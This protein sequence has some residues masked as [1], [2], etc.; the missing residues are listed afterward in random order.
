ML[1]ETEWVAPGDVTSIMPL[2]CD[3]YS[4]IDPSVTESRC[5]LVDQLWRWNGSLR[6]EKIMWFNGPSDKETAIHQ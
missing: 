1:I 2:R 6:I 3:N 5:V 4:Y